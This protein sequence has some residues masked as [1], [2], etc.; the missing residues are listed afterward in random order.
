MPLVPTGAILARIEA[1][2]QEQ[3]ALE[4]RAKP[5]MGMLARV[6]GF[7]TKMKRVTRG[8]GKLRQRRATL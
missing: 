8:N 3:P 4:T 2:G 1:A 6:F 7:K 5:K